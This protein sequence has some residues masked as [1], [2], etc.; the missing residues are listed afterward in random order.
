MNGEQ[1]KDGGEEPSGDEE[2]ATKSGSTTGLKRV[3]FSVNLIEQKTYHCPP[4]EMAT[5][6][7]NGAI[8]PNFILGDNG[9][10]EDDALEATDTLAPEMQQNGTKVSTYE[11]TLLE[12][13]RRL[14]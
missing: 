1:Q 4:E 11:Q 10:G 14:R 9:V 6:E 7:Q 13:R 3:S 8:K 5:E 2:A 12:K